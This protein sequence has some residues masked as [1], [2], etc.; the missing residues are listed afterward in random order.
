MTLAVTA[1]AAAAATATAKIEHKTTFSHLVIISC[2]L[3]YIYLLF[4]RV[5]IGQVKQT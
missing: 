2:W 5:L 1:A 4:V 3:I